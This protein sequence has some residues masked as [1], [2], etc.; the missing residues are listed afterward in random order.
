MNAEEALEKIPDGL[1]L[2]HA[3]DAETL[4]NDQDFNRR[5]GEAVLYGQIIQLYHVASKQYVRTSS[6]ATSRR[7]AR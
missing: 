4:D 7:E 6:T 1:R 3:A 5:L 2:K